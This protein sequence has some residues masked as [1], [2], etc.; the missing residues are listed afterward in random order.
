MV[1]HQRADHQSAGSAASNYG[2]FE[3]IAVQLC[4]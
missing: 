3:T 1:V 4:D 2:V